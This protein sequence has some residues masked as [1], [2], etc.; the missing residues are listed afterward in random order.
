MSICSHIKY[1]LDSFVLQVVDLQLSQPSL[2]HGDND[3][4]K[5]N[6]ILYYH[7]HQM[8]SKR[9]ASYGGYFVSKK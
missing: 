1:F 4:F 7:K 2:F 9:F 5:D 3:D 8:K 6:T